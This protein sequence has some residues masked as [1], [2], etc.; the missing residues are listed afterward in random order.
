MKKLFTM[1]LAVGM[2]CNAQAADLYKASRN[3][4]LRAPAVPLITSDPYL[5]IWSPADALNESSTM[6]WTGTEHPLLGAI[7]VD[8]KT[9]RFMGKDKLNLETLVP[10]TDTDTW[11]GSYT[12]DEPAAGWNTL[13]FNASGW[14]EGQGAFGT[15]DMPRV[16]TRWTTPDIWVRR[17]FQ[18]ND[19]MNGETI[20]LKYSHD[21]VFELYLNGEKL[22][23]TD[24]SWN[25]DVLLE[26]SD[27]AK[28]KLQKGKNVL[29]AHCHNTTGGAYVDFGLYRLNKQTTGFETAA[30]QNR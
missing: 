15:P 21:D 20:Y 30:V 26:L 2:L 24:Y 5:S 1:A 14:K 25:N 10:M 8:G 29:A 17:D 16:H 9:Y 18:I 6:H 11:Q 27:A 12:S 3:V 19:D 28:K 4:A 13:S 7:R 22:V 23:A